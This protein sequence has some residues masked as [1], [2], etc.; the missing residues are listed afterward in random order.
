[1]FDNDELL[2]FKLS[3]DFVLAALSSNTIFDL[4][5]LPRLAGVCFGRAI[6]ILYEEPS[7][8][9]AYLMLTVEEDLF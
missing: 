4:F 6:S 8:G 2:L 3:L 9:C 5:Y 1:M 7:I